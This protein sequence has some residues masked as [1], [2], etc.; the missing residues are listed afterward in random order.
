LPANDLPAGGRLRRQPWP[1]R[2]RS[3]RV[4][5]DAAFA[6]AMARSEFLRFNTDESQQ[7]EVAGSLAKAGRHPRP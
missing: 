2:R 1:W 4:G 5:A 7:R 3:R 6:K